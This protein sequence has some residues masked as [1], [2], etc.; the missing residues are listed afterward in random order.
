MISEAQR[1]RMEENRAAAIARFKS[2]TDSQAPIGLKSTINPSTYSSQSVHSIHSFSKTDI[3][4]WGNPL[5]LMQ[6]QPNYK[7]NHAASNQKI[8][9]YVRHFDFEQPYS[10]DNTHPTNQILQ[11]NE[12]SYHVEHLPID[13][14][15]NNS[16]VC[17]PAPISH[18]HF[19]N[20][21]DRRYPAC[22]KSRTNSDSWAPTGQCSSKSEPYAVDKHG[23]PLNIVKVSLEL[24]AFDQ[25]GILISNPSNAAR[26]ILNRLVASV[27]PILEASVSSPV[28]YHVKDY[29][30]VLCFLRDTTCV[31]V[32]H[33]PQTT[34]SMIQKLHHVKYSPQHWVPFMPN[35][36]S[37]AA[38]DEL[39][40][41]LPCRLKETLLPFQLEGV[42]FGLRR[43]GRCLIAD[44][45]GVGK[46]IQAISLAACYS[47]EGSILVACPASLRLMWAEELERW[48]PFM[49]PLDVHLVFGHKTKIPDEA[50]T[51]RVVVISYTMLRRL[52]KDMMARKWAL[53]IVDESHNLRCTRG[54]VECEETTTILAIAQNIKRIVLL[55]GTP[56][57]SRPFDIFHQINIV[58]PGLLGRSKY[59]FAK[60]YCLSESSTGGDQALWQK[61]D[62]SKGQR[63]HELNILLRET[64]MVCT[65]LAHYLP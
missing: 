32:Q 62:F 33:I 9:Y 3:P 40:Q 30:N 39:I 10:K 21:A 46:T 6:A 41:Q 25:F 31:I 45:M 34:F 59:D 11:I 19:L 2:K 63:L 14:Q 61:K 42:K 60:S 22:K 55:S 29:K 24:Q 36:I 52:R 47:K 48:L 50:K 58:S 17:G 51:P 1:K 37:D 49:S 18:T 4:E 15:Q 16:L 53:L 54:K 7:E 65:I 20:E 23:L 38:V 57:L 8:P 26:D 12:N 5:L 64:V 56:S 44:E 43:G 28:L 35:H 27:A 13:N